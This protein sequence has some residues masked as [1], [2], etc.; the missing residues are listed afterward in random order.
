MG[1]SK[2]YRRFVEGFLAIFI[3]FDQVE[4]K[5]GEISVILMNVRKIFHTLKDRL[6]LA[7][8]LILPEILDG[9]MLSCDVLCVSLGCILMQNGKVIAYASR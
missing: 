3:P 4:Q 6:T 2:Y 9:F 8:I 7:P 1:F 5:E